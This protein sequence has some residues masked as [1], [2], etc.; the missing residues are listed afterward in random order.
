MDAPLTTIRSCLASG[1]L[2]RNAGIVAVLVGLVVH[3]VF[4]SRA[5][6]DALYMDSLRLLAQL[7]QWEDG[8]MSTLDFWSQASAHRGFVNQAYLF[9]NV[10][11]FKLDVLLANRLTAL[12]IAGLSLGLVLAWCR[13]ARRASEDDH[14]RLGVL[15][16]LVTLAFALLCFSWAGYELLTL[17][18]GL[19]LW[20][21]NLLF[22][23]FFAG[24]ARLI[25]GDLSRPWIL[26]L[27]LT[28]AAPVIVMLVGMGWNYSFSLAVFAV[29]IFAFIPR[30]RQPGRWRALAPTIALLLSM[31]AYI[32]SGQLVHTAADDARIM[33]SVESVTLPFY[34]LGSSFG[35]HEALLGRGRPAEMFLLLG[36]LLVLM[37]TIALV[38]WL[39]RGAPG[40]RLPLYFVMYGGL[41][42]VS[43]SIARGMDGPGAVVASR[44]YMDIV[45]LLIGVLWMAA[46]EAA[47]VDVRYSRKA[48]GV[49]LTLLSLVLVG[50]MITY[51]HEWRAG[52]FRALVFDEMN[53]VTLRG[54]PDEEA[55]TL[56]Q[57]PLSLARQGADVMREER[58]AFFA[59]LPADYCS[60]DRI[61]YVS[62]W[63]KLE[64]QG[65]WSRDVA[66]L[67]LP[68]CECNFAAD[69]YLPAGLGQRKVEVVGID[70][71]T[72]TSILNEGARGRVDLGPA[73]KE[74]LVRLHVDP[75]TVP[76]RDRPGSQDRRVLGVLVNGISVSCHGAGG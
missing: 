71:M 39:R 36:V 29:Q 1:R 53:R 65:R 5:N 2:Q 47:A 16:L 4:L 74:G 55:A 76:F 72:R 37:G 10:H 8:R 69:V 24:H 25:V 19:P 58:L 50:H 56:L 27:V 61:V 68:K 62:G 17:D 18:L 23:G 49:V 70:G 60:T 33:I 46:R 34:A 57:S 31:S 30:W 44:Y 13:D 35:A 63:N 42:A 45:L 3:L 41:V 43:V 75:V 67:Q 14:H 9:A 12:L 26:Q 7:Q 15:E 38:H 40:S 22:V 52:P 51:A 73:T 6:P 54:V 64:A 11:L 20:T 28:L 59:D 21:K 66:E 32:G 48:K